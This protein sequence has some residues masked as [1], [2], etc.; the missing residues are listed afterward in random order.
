MILLKQF[1]REKIWLIA[2][3]RKLCFVSFSLRGHIYYQVTDREFSLSLDKGKKLAVLNEILLFLK[4]SMQSCKFLVSLLQLF[5]MF[6]ICF[7]TTFL[8]S[9]ID[10]SPFSLSLNSNLTWDSIHRPS[11][12]LESSHVFLL[13]LASSHSTLS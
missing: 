1:F 11:Y 2:N 3:S 4:S 12:C 7:V 9:T 10:L 13:F 5:I 8:Y 6:S